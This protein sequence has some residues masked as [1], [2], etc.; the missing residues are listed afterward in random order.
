MTKQHTDVAV[1]G[2]GIVGLAHAWAAAKRG[3]KVTLFERTE[4]AVGASIRNFGLIWPIGQPFGP[5]HDHAMR[6][7]ELWEGVAAKA[8]LYRMGTGSLHLAYREDEQAVLEEFF[9]T[10]Q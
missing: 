10:A 1:V 8:G 5:A 6:A 4:W 7:R 9:A 2:A 3:L